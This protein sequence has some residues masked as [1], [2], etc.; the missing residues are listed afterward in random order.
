MAGRDGH[1]ATEQSEVLATIGQR[2][3]PVS[4]FTM[5][6]TMVQ[7]RGVGGWLVRIFAN[8]QSPPSPSSASTAQPPHRQIR[9]SLSP[10]PLELRSAFGT[11]HSS[12]TGRL[13]ALFHVEV[14]PF[15][16]YGEV[17][18]P[19]R[20]AG[21][22]EAT[23]E[24]CRCLFH[25][26][27]AAVSNTLSTPVNTD[28]LADVFE[29]LKEE[30]SM[31]GFGPLVDDTSPTGAVFRILLAALDAQDHHPRHAAAS[32][33]ESAILLS[34]CQSL[35]LPLHTA[36]GLSASPARPGFYTAALR[37]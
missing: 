31:A 36:C 25:H 19:P 28:Q 13:N 22:Y 4:C 32:G 33:L 9:L 23:Y 2:Q 24:D 7:V 5:L 29:L 37:T 27:A 11:S 18:L 6:L 3:L 26:F 8:I 10:F 14:G 1:S 15:Q 30:A 17:G 12:T 20:K 35:G 34:W 16:G 21:V